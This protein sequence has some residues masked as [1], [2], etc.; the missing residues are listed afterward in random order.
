MKFF[1]MNYG[2]KPPY[3]VLMDPE[4]IATSL[5]KKVFVK[6]AVP[7]LLA[8][9]AVLVV[10]R[11]VTA[12]LRA[13]GEKYAAAALMAKRLQHEECSHERPL[14]PHNCL[15][16]LLKQQEE[17]EKKL[18]LASQNRRFQTRVREL[19]G[20]PMLH[21]S[22]TMVLLDPPTPAS[23][24]HADTKARSHRAIKPV[25][26][27]LV[28]EAIQT[29]KEDDA[30]KPA[31]KAI[32]HRV[33]AQKK[34]AKGPNPLSMRKKGSKPLLPKDNKSAKPAAAA[35]TTTT[36]TTTASSSSSSG[37]GGGASEE[38]EQRNATP[39]ASTSEAQGEEAAQTPD[40]RKRKRKR[41][42]AG[43]SKK[44]SE[45]GDE[46]SS[47]TSSSSPNTPAEGAPAKKRRVEE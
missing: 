25:E 30:S 43:S 37:G 28:K 47:S 44:A 32:P 36:T 41:K 4:F 14:H 16:S 26:Q 10:T 11:C 45:G 21:I 31:P 34:R 38:A 15:F 6:T 29:K 8:G 5:E 40:K 23:T 20:I 12:H 22:N 19:P 46:A 9:S 13:G 27:E 42:H 7:E 24:K 35:A 33:M 2:V 1:K 3:F 39:K 17:R 18:C